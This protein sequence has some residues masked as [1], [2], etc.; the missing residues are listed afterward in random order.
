MLLLLHGKSD[1]AIEH[2]RQVVRF[3]PNFADTH[4]AL[5]KALVKQGK[6]D[7]A[8]KHYNE[9]LRIKPDWVALM[10]NLAWLLATN[11]ESK[12]HNPQKAIQFAELACKLTEYTEPSLLD[13]L[14]AAYATAAKFDRAIENAEKAIK[15]CENAGETE[16]AKEIR[17]RL[18][19]YKANKAYYEK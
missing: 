14:A 17:S 13:T 2:L 4:Y 6:L 1:E 19:L 15:L 7:E 5:G 11:K 16:L 12:I 18:Q 3:Q 9:A 10:N 8:V